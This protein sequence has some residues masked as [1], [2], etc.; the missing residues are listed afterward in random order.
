MVTKANNQ[1]L[2]EDQIERAVEREM[3]MLDRLLMSNAISQKQYD[4]EVKDL[5]HWAK[6]EYKYIRNR[7]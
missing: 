5:D 4:Q 2:N 7:R 6:E 1:C 3:N